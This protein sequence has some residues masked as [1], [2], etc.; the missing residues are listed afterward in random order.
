VP[1]AVHGGSASVLHSIICGAPGGGRK[2]KT[3][4]YKKVTVPTKGL[5]SD[6]TSQAKLAQ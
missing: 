3:L 5:V 4:T 2:A 1:I 6:I